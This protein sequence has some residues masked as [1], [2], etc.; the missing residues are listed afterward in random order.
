[1][2][3]LPAIDIKGG[4]VARYDARDGRTTVYASDPIAQAEQVLAQG[5]TWLHV[6]DLDRAFATGSDNDPLIMRIAK[7]PGAQVQL[8]GN[9]TTADDA[10]RGVTLGAQRVV[11]S[12]SALLNDVALAEIA[13][14][15]SSVELAAA[16]DVREGRVTLRG[17]PRVIAETPAQL[18]ARA[19]NVG[20][21]IIVY[22]DLGR[23]GL[24]GGASIA[25][26]K[27]LSGRGADVVVAGG[28][29]SLDDIRGARAAGLAGIIVGR[30]L[31]EGRFTFAEA[32]ACSR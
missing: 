19:L 23:D 28:A 24:L 2:E 12:T 30:A 22:R 16:I 25:D 26:A 13:K 29:A 3:L 15:A 8:G 1:M 10:R 14:A 6:V 20:V 11:A 31:Y 32:L 27:R 18:A 4:Q 9:L 7:L 21:R 5:A 17:D